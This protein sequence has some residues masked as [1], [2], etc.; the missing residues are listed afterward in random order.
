[1]LPS[2]VYAP[3]A[4]FCTPACRDEFVNSILIMYMSLQS[5]Q[6]ALASY[7]GV[8]GAVRILVNLIHIITL[9][10]IVLAIYEVNISQS[11]VPLTTML[12]GFGFALGPTLQRL[13]ESLLFVLVI[14]PFDVG[15][16]VS[17]P[18]INA[19]G[20]LTVAKLNLLT[21]EFTDGTN[22]R[23]IMRNS[24]LGAQPI[25]NMR[26]SGEAAIVIKFWVNANISMQAVDALSKTLSQYV[27]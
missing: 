10:L 6:G 1:M 18:M 11:L 22:K 23:L 27:R 25:F 13:L 26:R 3:T 4:H 7:G 2:V 14:S 21:T 12:I 17:V 8:S 16:K 20:W 5:T 15:D 24:E 9:V 19:G